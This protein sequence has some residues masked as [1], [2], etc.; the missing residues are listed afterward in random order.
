MTFL[1]RV[2]EYAYTCQAMQH[3]VQIHDHLY[4]IR[5]TPTPHEQGITPDWNIACCSL[6]AY[7]TIAYYYSYAQLYFSVSILP[8][9]LRK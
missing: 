6:W 4:Q 7:N 8:R 2:Q 5:M 1:L 3:L 9:T